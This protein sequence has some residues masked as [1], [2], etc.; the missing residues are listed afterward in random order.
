M[1]DYT[2]TDAA[3]ASNSGAALE[4]EVNG[5]DGKALREQAEYASLTR[6][7]ATDNSRALVDDVLRLIAQT[8]TRERQRGPKA[9]ASL[10]QAVEGFLADLLAAK[11][12]KG[13]AGWVFRSV[14]PSTFTGDVVSARNFKAV[15]VAL[16]E[17]GLVEEAPA[18]QLWSGFEAGRVTKRWT[19]RFCGPPEPPLCLKAA[20]TRDRVALGTNNT[21]WFYGPQH[22]CT[23]LRSIGAR[24]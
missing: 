8:E 11:G 5:R 7:A 2:E 18:V 3:V 17:L 1:R 21:P 22:L 9:N 16:V 14:A 6:R 15:R 10:R 12:R 19:T 13:D 24:V 4:A 23:N 20:W